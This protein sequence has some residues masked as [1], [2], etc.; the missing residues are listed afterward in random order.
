MKPSS[1]VLSQ[2]CFNEDALMYEN[3]HGHGNMA[4]L[5]NATDQGLGKDNK[6]R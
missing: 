5:V 2:P 4:C 1:T 6:F 3:R